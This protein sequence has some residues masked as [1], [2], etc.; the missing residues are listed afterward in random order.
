MAVA[1]I[2]YFGYVSPSPPDTT[3]NPGSVLGLDR[4]VYSYCNN[5]SHRR[6]SQTDIRNSRN[7][8]DIIC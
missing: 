7:G 5:Y 8:D 2:S 1:I 4:Q 3:S 6:M